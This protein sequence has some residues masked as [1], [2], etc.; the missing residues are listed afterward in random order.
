V[1]HENVQHRP[2]LEILA[3][4]VGMEHEIERGMREMKDLLK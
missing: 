3:E 2:P 1:V 4:L